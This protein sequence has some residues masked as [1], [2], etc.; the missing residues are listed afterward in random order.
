M[1]RQRALSEAACL[2]T[3]DDYY[4]SAVSSF[5]FQPASQELNGRGPVRRRPLGL[6]LAAVSLGLLG[7]IGLF[8]SFSVL[9]VALFAHTTRIPPPPILVG[10]EIAIGLG[11][12]VVSALCVLVMIGLFQI[13]HWARIGVSL[14]GGFM[15]MLLG[16]SA[17]GCI[18]FAFSSLVNTAAPPNTPNVT[19]AMMRVAFLSMGFAF[20]LLTTVGIWWL[21]YFNLQR[22][23]ELFAA[24]GLATAPADA[25]ATS[26]VKRRSLTEILLICLAVIY[27]LG[28]IG[29][30][31]LALLHLPFFFLGMILRGAA[32][33]IFALSI[34]AIS[35][36]IGIGLLR[37][38]KLAWFVAIGWQAMGLLSCLMLFLP[39][40]RAA[41]AAYQ[42]ELQQQ[43]NAWAPVSQSA[44][45]QFAQSPANALSSAVFGLVVG[46]AILWLLL[47]ARP[48]F[49]K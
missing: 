32:G 5:D 46:L 35:V 9:A 29:G 37:R 22:T 7:C 14:I 21:V 49:E 30:P 8:S 20:L 43:M 11:M 2:F 45:S 27:L 40:T 31:V 18:I 38:M 26:A 15:A 1:S 23:R 12:L 3:A 44:A 36:G 6:I 10:M 24:G 33:T 47:R 16:L 34:S 17:I 13:K 28:A 25:A 42:Q 39:S 19:P 48:L 4:L 41:M